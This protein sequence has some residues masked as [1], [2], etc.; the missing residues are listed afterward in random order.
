MRRSLTCSLC[1]ALCGLEVEVDGGAVTSVRGD[2]E[3]PLSR[4]HICPKAVALTDLHDDPDRLKGPMRRDAQGQW[5]PVSWGEALGEVSR[6]LAQVQAEHG[7]DAVGLYVGNPMAHNFSGALALQALK[8]ALGS[9]NLTS[10]TSADQ[11][12]HMFAALLMFGH[13]LALPVPDVDRTDLMIIVGANP[14]ASNGSLM[15]APGIMKRLAA[16]RSRGGEVIVLDPRRTRTA[17]AAD[18]HYFIRPGT[19]ALFLLAMLHVI[20]EE[21]LTRPGLWQGYSKGLSAL[22]GA[23][24]G[25]SPEAVAAAVG[26]EAEV[27]RGLARKM[28]RARS[29]ALYGRFG[30]C[31]QRFGGLCAWLINAINVVTG[32][33]DRPG[34]LM[35]ARPAA[36]LADLASL[37]GQ[38]GSYD[39]W[40]SRVSNLPEFSGELPVSALAEEMLTPGPGQ[41][42]A[43]ITVA[44][45]P[46]LST[47]N[48]AQLDRAMAS[49]DFMVAV[50]LYLNETTRHAHIILP[51]VSP[52][53]RDHYGLIFHALAV[54]NTARFSPPLFD[55]PVGDVRPDWSIILDMAR[56]LLKA[57][58]GIEGHL[59]ALA[60]GAMAR[61]GPRRWLDAALRVGPYGI[62]AQGLTL[63]RLLEAPHG[64]DLGPLTPAL[65]ER[66]QSPDGLLDLAPDVLVA[67]V[68][69]L[70][71]AWTSGSLAPAGGLALIGRR[72]LRSLNSWMHNSDRLVRGQ[73][74]CT[75]LIHPDDAGARGIADGQ[76]VSITS[77]TGAVEVDA[78]LDAAMMPGV[79]S[80]PHGWGHARPGAA[81]SVAARRPGASVNDLTDEIHLDTL[82]GTAGFS[83]VPVEVAPA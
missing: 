23:A 13:Q 26:V 39:R 46:A 10:A 45:N 49:L 53:E 37:V 29:A 11:L 16:I 22:K 6:R 30:I 19:D 38:R 58:G 25:F 65:P 81:L 48:G 24:L 34:G 36:D 28:A 18:A 56:G 15:T 66:L 83:G 57:R 42:R 41:L 63:D 9:R 27:T 17:E 71:E 51:P 14:A 1:E 72:D 31:T 33:F 82:T 20:F 74:R 3:D 44:G 12:P 76:R 40:R 79:V 75:L 35:F 5:S 55:S 2:A 52:L 4:G 68:E 77:R 59:G 43:L 32:H 67:D 70:R 80:L 62:G 64:I 21:G 73:P 7:R 54:R 50:D 60:V 8:Q 69:R 61:V 47:P 78:A